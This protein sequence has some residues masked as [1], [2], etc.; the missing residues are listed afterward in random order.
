LEQGVYDD[1]LYSVGTFDSGLGL[2]AWRSALESVGATIPTEPEDAWTVEE[3]TQIL[4]DL[5]AAGF[6]HPLDIKVF[7]GSQGEWFTYAFA[8]ILWSG[9]GDLIDRDDYQSA[10][11]VL[12]SEES[13]EAMTIFQGWVDEELT[14]TNAVDDAGFLSG[15]DSAL[16]WVG[17][18]N[19]Q[20]NKEALGDDMVVV[21][22]PDFGEGTRTGMGSW[23]WG[24]TSAGAANDGDAAWAFIDYALSDDV[25]LEVTGVNGAVPATRTALDKSPIYAEGGDLEIFVKQLEGAPDVAMPRPVTPAYPNMTTEFR[26]VIDKIILG[27]DVKTTL[28]EAVAVIDADIAANDGYPPPSEQ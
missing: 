16:A 5:Q 26:V 1:V 20:L 11:G 22:L 19:Y 28:D 24:I 10:D 23:A 15:E 27:A 4:R 7:Y 17:H 25:I 6:P 8:P 14:A 9:G 18:W 2:Y 21:P 3:F 12:N 13:V